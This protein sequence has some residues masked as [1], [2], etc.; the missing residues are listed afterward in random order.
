[1]D[2]AGKKRWLIK[3]KDGR[4][5]GPFYTDDILARIQRGEITGEEKISLFPNTDWIPISNDPQFYDQLLDSLDEERSRV[6]SEVQ[7]KVDFGDSLVDDL[8][9]D[10]VETKPRIELPPEPTKA[11]K[12]VQPTRGRAEKISSTK[13]TPDAPPVIEP[14]V[15]AKEEKKVND[16]KE[17]RSSRDKSK[18]TENKEL[19]V[20]ELKKIKDVIQ[21]AKAKRYPLPI[22][23]SVLVVLLL[24]FF[25]WPS[26]N[27]SSERIHLLAPRPQRPALAAADVKMR[28]QKALAQYIADNF[29]SY[30]KAQSELVQILEG[31]PKNA[32][33]IALTCLTYFELWP[34]AHQDSADLLTIS[35][36]AQ[37]ASRIDPAG[38]EAGTCRVVDLLV[39]GRV[40]EAKGVAEMVLDTF[41]RSGTPPI[42]FYYFK[43]LLFEEA[44]D[45]SAAI[46][47]AQ[48]AQQLWSQWL[49]VHML[50]ASLLAKLN[51]FN[52]AANKY[53][54]IL[55]ANSNHKVAQIELGIIEY[56][57]L[58]NYQKG[59]DLLEMAL[60]SKERAPSETMARAYLTLAEI[61]LRHKNQKEALAY[62][63]K[64]YALN[65]SNVRIKEIILSLGGEKKLQE[66]QVKDTQL[67]Y[68][69]DLL[70][71]E[72]DCNAAQ[73][74]YKAAYDMNNKN[75]V[76]AMKA[77]E[78]LWA[79]SLSSDAIKW[80][81][82]AIR[83]DPKL[84]DA[85]VLLADYYS[86]KFNFQAASQI[87]AKG[88]TQ[89]PNSYKVF[90]GFALVEL[91]RNNFEASAKYASRAVAVYE[92]DVESH[93]I[94]ARARLGMN[95]QA[96]AFE[97]AGKA[98]EIDMNNRQAQVT[99]AQALA[100]TQGIQT[101]IDYLNRLVNTYPT[102]TEYRL[103]LGQMYAQDQSYNMAEQLFQQVI[104]IEDKPKL[105]YLE[106]GKVYHAQNRREEARDAYFKAAAL[107]PSDAQPL[108]L[109]GRLYLEARQASEAREQFRRVM[110]VNADYPL[111]NYYMGNAALQMGSTSEALEQAKIEKAKNPNLADPYLLSAEAYTEM[112]QYSACAGEY[113]QA[114][115]LRQMNSDIYVKMARCYRLSGNIDAAMSMVNEASRQESGNPEVW[116]EQGAI[117]EMKQEAVKAIEA[118][119]QY[120]VLAPNAPDREQIQTR[121]NTLSR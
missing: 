69:G 107:D 14:K 110:R 53:R 82:L 52:E 67:L 54:S 15:A 74:H 93:V 4:V 91:R 25:L 30:I 61:M 57:Q 9:S 106:L 49:R 28:E 102:L 105:A 1:M 35:N 79:V 26:A 39:R 12:T 68:E 44:K 98:I 104:K 36:V 41:G 43:A 6:D 85:Y 64:A 73:A 111:V 58:Q 45:Y 38:I 50:E 47:Y 2:D 8:P 5:R 103:A 94:L 31:D 42:A 100:A 65:P 59:R 121:I 120:L 101:G 29:S 11:G 83:A 20:I 81:D 109:A 113:Q 89:T 3:D 10:F 87:L 17:K 90:R 88:A 108:F 84:T 18:K 77:A 76:A 115:R 66:T 32:G 27:T 21:R 56:T 72:G 62:A 117:F 19:P 71:K 116:K 37:M 80:L 40:V 13:T 60:S 51:R 48:S 7:A 78:C 99:Y 114:V 16:K 97:S 24:A 55:K 86:Q 63:Q 96:K 22:A 92:A 119:N 34:Y 70:V 33:V 75:A 112:K 118:Y 23:V 95:E 46:S